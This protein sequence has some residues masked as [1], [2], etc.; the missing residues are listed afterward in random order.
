FRH[1][2]IPC[3]TIDEYRSWDFRRLDGSRCE[4]HDLPLARSLERGVTVTG[5]ELL[6]MRGATAL[7]TVSAS[8][9]PIRDADGR[10]AGGGG[11]FGDIPGRKRAGAGRER[12]VGELR[13]SLKARDE[14]LAVASHELRTPLTSLRLQSESLLLLVRSFPAEVQARLG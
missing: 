9:A 3:R 12:L 5:E 8:S 1:P 7:A 10:L 14:F 2:F 13:G 6:V 11:A 4:P